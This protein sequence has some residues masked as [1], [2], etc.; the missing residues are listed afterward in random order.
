MTTAEALFAR[1][2]YEMTS[3][4]QITQQAGVNLAAVNYHFSDKE[5]LYR[6]IIVRRLQPINQGRLA[7]LENA[8]HLAG[9]EPVALEQILLIFI[10]P[11]FELAQDPTRGGQH[12]VRIISRSMVE[13]LPFIDE[14]LAKEFHPITSRFAQALRRHVPRL[15]PDDFLWR[16]SFIVGAMHH[17][18]ATLHCINELTQGICRNNDF[19]GAVSRL[20]QYSATTLTAPSVTSGS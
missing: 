20:I 17:T 18:L 3:L 4:R 9:S 5:S 10:K 7:N 15:P 2:G 19:D 13:P 1:Q 16:I 12:I 11:V 6:K 14:L 8:E